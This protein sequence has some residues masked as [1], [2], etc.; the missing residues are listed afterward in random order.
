[1]DKARTG[2]R[3]VAAARPVEVGLRLLAALKVAGISQA[4]LCR[5]TGI[6]SS[7]LSQ[8]ITGR[9][10]PSLEPLLI[11][12]PHLQVDLNYLYMGDVSAFSYEKRDALL[13][14]ANTARIEQGDR[15]EDLTGGP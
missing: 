11:A 15:E 10:R 8:W 12:L 6:Q 13:E 1:M 3:L 14:A 5:A 4:D 9:N 2:R 7:Q